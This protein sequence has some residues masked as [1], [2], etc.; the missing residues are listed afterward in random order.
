MPFITRQQNELVYLTSP[1]LDAQPGIAHGF[2]TRL[3][4]VSA[5]PFD[6][7]NLGVGRGDDSDAVRENYWRFC[8]CIGVDDH[9]VVLSKQIHETTVR[10]CTS[11]DAGKGLYAKR[12]YTADALVTNEPD[13][14]LV[15]FS[16][17]CGILLLHDPISGAVGASHAGWRGC[18]AGIVEKTVE[19][20]HARFG[21]RPENLVTAIGASIA[22]CCFETDDDVPEAM[23]R[24]L[25]AKA[26]GYL[27]HRGAKWHVDLAGLNR[28]WLLRA[29][30]LPAHID[31][32]GLCTACHPEWFWSHRKMGN[33]RGAQI[34]LIARKSLDEGA[35][36]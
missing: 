13:L 3:G 8:A 9:R 11:A 27:E 10:V 35:S 15:V 20:M 18:A 2:S 29:G 5:A 16:A 6:T 26:E 23:R 25:G 28:E 4:G 17:D 12:D 24:A 14:P 22:S 36:K 32:C 21:S 34:A 30:V 7:L 33:A 31:M 1:L 19:T